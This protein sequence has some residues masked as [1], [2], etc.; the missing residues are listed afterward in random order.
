MQRDVVTHLA[1]AIWICT[2]ASSA[3]AH[4]SHPMYYDFCKSIT[5]EGRVQGVEWKNPHI[6]IEFALDDGT[7]YHAE[8]TS[9]QGLTNN[10]V[11]G[12]AQEAVRFGERVVVTGNPPRDPALGRRASRSE[13]TP[14][15]HGAVLV[16]VAALTES[17]TSG[18]T[19]SPIR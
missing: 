14:D 19:S 1:T 7:T 12:R 16:Q 5:I 3:R 8:W 2:A 11:G 13:P 9:L 4:H 15:R 18:R 10:G 6:W 17:V